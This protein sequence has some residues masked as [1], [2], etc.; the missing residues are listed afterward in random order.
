[1]AYT[2]LVTVMATLVTI[3]TFLEGF[4]R[5]RLHRSIDHVGEQS[6]T[7]LTELTKAVAPFA[8]SQAYKEVARQD[9]D[10]PFRL[11]KSAGA[12][13]YGVLVAVPISAALFALLVIGLAGSGSVFEINPAHW[14]PLFTAAL[15]LFIAQVA[16]AVL[17]YTDRRDNEKELARARAVYVARL[18]NEAEKT[19]HGDSPPN[20]EAA[21]LW[22]DAV[23]G[24]KK[25]LPPQDPASG[26]LQSI[27]ARFH[28]S[29]ALELEQRASGSDT[30][31]VAPQNI[32]SQLLEERKKARELLAPPTS[33]A[34]PSAL[35]PTTVDSR[36]A[37]A[38]VLS[39]DHDPSAADALWDA[40][41][42]YGV[43]R[44]S[45]WLLAHDRL[46]WAEVIRQHS[47]KDA[48]AFERWWLGDLAELLLYAGS[49]D[50]KQRRERCLLAAE[51]LRAARR[52][53]DIP[54]ALR[55][56]FEACET[57][58]EAVNVWL[59]LTRGHGFVGAAVLI[60][61]IQT[62]ANR[63]K[64][65]LTEADSILAEE[66]RGLPE[67]P[68]GWKAIIDELRRMKLCDA[69]T[70]LAQA[71]PGKS[72]PGAM[73]AWLS[74]LDESEPDKAESEAMSVALDWQSDDAD[75][76]AVNQQTVD[77]VVGLLARSSEEFYRSWG[78]RLKSQTAAWTGPKTG[79]T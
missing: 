71:F 40:V 39:I 45:R 75:R 5:A 46:A 34:S 23:V 33:A 17:T 78:E 11:P 8:R 73:L 48:D 72:A 4:S 12:I 58:D 16:L 13:R 67:D 68:V 49:R 42:A 63:D 10:S 50:A 20:A 62:A 59:E 54:D 19:L 57:P 52:P 31:G 36:L 47:G 51:A 64:R 35:D 27:E 55:A 6:H 56:M 44:P 14:D 60:P 70:V 29:V 25:H 26:I 3:T 9:F 79:V 65:W 38:V 1:M 18:V 74:L 2:P 24:T 22:A 15:V 43:A 66:A 21:R 69:T 61:L 41:R 77:A 28:L 30:G 32:G 76:R 37:Y 7:L 53:F